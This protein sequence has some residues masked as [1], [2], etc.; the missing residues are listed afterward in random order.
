M[1]NGAIQFIKYAYPPNKLRYCGPSNSRAIFDYFS[2]NKSDEGLV[3]LLSKFNGAYPN[4][5]YIAQ[6]NK[7]KN[8]FDTRVVEAYW[9]GNNLLDQVSINNYY[10]YLRDQFKGQ[11]DNHA[12]NVIF[13]I[14]KSYSAKPHHSFHVLSLFAKKKKTRKILEHISNCL[15]LSGKVVKIDLEGFTVEYK[16]IVF[17]NNKLLFGKLKSKKLNC[18]G[19]KKFEINENVSFHWNW[20]CDKITDTQIKNLDFWN[21]F[22]L[23]LINEII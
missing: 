3:E 1:Q 20:I 19:I 10:Q 2:H 5:C 16:P 13:G 8:P 6:T 15:I 7:I 14:S 12:L 4:L 11:W 21:R 23:D 17:K 9:I 22:H 18:V